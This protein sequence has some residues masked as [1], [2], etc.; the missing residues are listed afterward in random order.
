MTPR[1]IDLGPI[2]PP[3]LQDGIS[4]GPVTI[5][6]YALC[7]L[8]GIVVAVWWGE[9]RWVGMGGEPGTVLDAAA[10]AVLLGIV[11]GRLYHVIS[12]YQL[13]F[14]PDSPNRPWEALAI[15]QGGLGI[16]GAIPMGALG[17]WIV[18]RRKGISLTKFSFAVAPGIALAQGIGRWGNYFNQELF[19]ASTNLPWAVYIQDRHVQVVEQVAGIQLPGNTFHPTFLYESLWCIALAALLAW[20]GRR[21]ETLLGGGRLFAVY[22]MGYCLG[23]FWIEYLR[24]DPANDILGMRLNNWTTLAVFA[25]ALAYFLWAGRNQERFSQVVRPESPQDEDRTTV[26]AAVSSDVAGADAPTD[27]A[28]DQTTPP[29][30][31]ADTGTGVRAEAEIGAAVDTPAAESESATEID[32]EADATADTADPESQTERDSS[33]KR[34]TEVHPDRD[35]RSED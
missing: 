33:S 6:I 5:Q 21:Y 1:L 12:D 13:Y 34:D 3:P 15:W 25:G 7:I 2:P 10:P 31:D 16:W 28:T 22:V 20:L 17:V 9:R 11:G 14:L 19:G 32:A 24:V 26:P 29:G 35:G 18:V 8:A 27:G 23:R 4:L 30:A